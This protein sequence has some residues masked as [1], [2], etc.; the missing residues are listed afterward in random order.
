[1]DFPHPNFLSLHV[2]FDIFV[3]NT[4]FYPIGQD[5]AAENDDWSHKKD[6]GVARDFAFEDDEL[7]KRRVSVRGSGYGVCRQ[8]ASRLTSDVSEIQLAELAKI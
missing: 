4:T 1:M 2:H 5:S 7:D 3:H 8:A 6:V